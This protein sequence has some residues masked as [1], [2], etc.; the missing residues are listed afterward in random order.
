MD[1]KLVKTTTSMLLLA[2]LFSCSPI[3]GTKKLNTYYG[4]KFFYPGSSK[5]KP[6]PKIGWVIAYKQKAFYQCLFQGYKNDSIL[7]LI[8]KEDL[9]TTYDFIPFSTFDKIK[10]DSKKIIDNISPNE[11]FIEDEET[12]KRN[13][14]SSTCLCYFAS[15]ELDSIAKNEYKLFLKDKN[16]RLLF[17]K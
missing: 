3:E 17:E 7:K 2:T 10:S 14:I 15:R 4:D 16:N 6:S 8:K 11:Y 5:N 9:F 1:T 13:Y 12:K